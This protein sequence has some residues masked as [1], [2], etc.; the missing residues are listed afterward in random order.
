MSLYELLL[1]FTKSLLCGYG[2][3]VQTSSE[4][5]LSRAD[6]FRESLQH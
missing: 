2:R 6:G 5:F 1:E 4:I 3:G